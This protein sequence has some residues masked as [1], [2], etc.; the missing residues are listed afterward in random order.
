MM[1]LLIELPPIVSAQRYHN[2]FKSGN[3]DTIKA[4]TVAKP[5]DWNSFFSASSTFQSNIP[6]AEAM[7]LAEKAVKHF[8][9]SHIA[10]KLPLDSTPKGCASREEAL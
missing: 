3:R 8:P 10:W 6:T 2:L 5:Y 7:S 1:S 9:N 4:A